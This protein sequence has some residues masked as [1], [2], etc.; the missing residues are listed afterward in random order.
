MAKKKISK[1][2]K[3]DYKKHILETLKKMRKKDKSA[4]LQHA[5]VKVK[6]EKSYTK[7]EDRK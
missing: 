5:M 6:K 1:K 3:K 4:T 2:Q 7:L